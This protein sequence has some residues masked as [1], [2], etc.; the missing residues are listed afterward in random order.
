[1]QVTYQCVAGDT[2]TVL[3]KGD[4]LRT[5]VVSHF[6]VSNADAN[7]SDT[8]SLFLVPPGGSSSINNAIIH[9]VKISASSYIEGNGGFVVP[10]GYTVTAQASQ[11]SVMVCTVSGEVIVQ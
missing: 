6:I 7:G 10:P 3:Y 8:I 4:P 9:L 11:P 5:L 1:M 2:P